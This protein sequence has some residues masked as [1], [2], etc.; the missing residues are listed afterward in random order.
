MA[1][2]CLLYLVGLAAAP[3]SCFPF[4]VDTQAAAA[5]SVSA[6]GLFL[7]DVEGLPLKPAQSTQG[8]V[9]FYDR[10]AAARR[11]G[12]ADV[13]GR[14]TQALR[15]RFT[16]R[17]AVTT[18]IGSQTWSQTNEATGYA[19][20]TLRTKLVPGAVLRVTHVGLYTDQVVQGVALK[21]D[22][23]AVGT[24]ATNQ[25]GQPLALT[26]PLDG[27]VHTLSA[28]LPEGVR[29]RG[30]KFCCGGCGGCTALTTYFEDPNN[31]LAGGF[32]LTASVGCAP[33]Q[34][35]IVCYAVEADP[36]LRHM[37]GQAV[38][39]AAARAYCVSLLTDT[40]NRNRYTALTPEQVQ[41]AISVY[42]TK[43]I[44][45]IEWLASG[46]ALAGLQHPC[47]FS[48]SGSAGPSISKSY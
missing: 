19:T 1:S 29:T 45:H 33:E 14:L 18:N 25:G 5:L 27:Q 46:Q 10:L 32:T 48:T 12:V 7:A 17:P 3:V 20:L 13:R 6:T 24:L 41:D 11:A 37:L 36:E 21:L 43:L 44:Q 28:L 39:F 38:L 31:T 47:Y 26:I 35:D 34:A 22:A 23:E 8:T 30:N 42:E 16:L 2:D 15:G 9:D 40:S 4:P